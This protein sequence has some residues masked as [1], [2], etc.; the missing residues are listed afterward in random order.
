MRDG[1]KN[2]QSQ[3]ECRFIAQ[4]LADS[5]VFFLVSKYNYAVWFRKVQRTMF[6]HDLVVPIKNY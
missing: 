6:F 1:N 3:E 2:T 4:I 5:F